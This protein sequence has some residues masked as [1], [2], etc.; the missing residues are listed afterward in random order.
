MKSMQ[1]II[2][3]QAELKESLVGKELLARGAMLA[4][5]YDAAERIYGEI[6]R[7]SLEAKAYFARKAFGSEDWNR[8]RKLTEELIEEMPDSIVLHEN[9]AAIAAAEQGGGENAAESR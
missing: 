9:L 6:E 1:A 3:G 8:A 5:E 2:A 4:G 7:D